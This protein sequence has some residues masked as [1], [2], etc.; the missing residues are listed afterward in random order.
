VNWETGVNAWTLSLGGRTVTLFLLAMGRYV[1]LQGQCN[2]PKAPG[3]KAEGATRETA[4]FLLGMAILRKP[5]RVVV[6]P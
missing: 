4:L 3:V 2:T 5:T 1:A 6:T